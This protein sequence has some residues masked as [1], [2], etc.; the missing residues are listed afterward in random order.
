MPVIF[1]VVSQEPSVHTQVD[2]KLVTPV[3]AKDFLQPVSALELLMRKDDSGG[4]E[5]ITG[6]LLGK[7]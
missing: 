2:Y 1:G 6:D 5:S 4:S 3:S 7:C